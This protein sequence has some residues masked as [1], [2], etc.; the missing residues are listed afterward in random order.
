MSSQKTICKS[1][2]PGLFD[3]AVLS[4]CLAADGFTWINNYHF[5]AVT[6]YYVHEDFM[7]ESNLFG[8]CN[9]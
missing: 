3:T 8:C 5:T 6:A 2:I 9:F 7:M 1:V 4:V